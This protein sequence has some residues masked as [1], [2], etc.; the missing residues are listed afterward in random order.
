[1]AMSMKTIEGLHILDAT[2]RDGGL[3][4]D[5]FFTDDFVKKV[6][7]TNVAAGLDYMEM[8]YRA[9]KKMFE[10]SK[11][12]KWKFSSD[13]DIRNIVGENPT[14]I[15]LSVMADVGRC[16]FRNDIHKKS[17]S[18][19]DLVRVATYIETIPEAVEMIEFAAKQG[20]ETTCNI[21][22]IS[23]CTMM[24]LSQA[25]EILAQSPVLGVYI[26]DSYGAL[27]PKEVRKI[28]RLFHDKLAPYGKLTGVHAHNN[29]QCAFANTIEGKDSGA[30][31]LDCT[32]YGMGRGAGN[33]HTEAL[34]GYLNGGKYRVEP[35]LKLVQDEMLKLKAQEPTWG[36]NTS[37]LITGLA[38]AHPRDAIAATKKHDDNFVEQFEFQLYK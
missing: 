1:M 3:V 34:L 28:T 4:N 26:V 20:Y 9:D 12:G 7:E 19:V 10:P 14:R 30:R 2:I 36:Y 15:K 27:Y 25:L 22:A 16:D 6:Y 5:F 29:Q 24:Q 32:M 11:F 31:L 37:Y 18:P 21:M 35:V 13:E 23:K 33:C 17:E 38:N 8:G